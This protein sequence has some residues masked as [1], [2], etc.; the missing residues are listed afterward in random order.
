MARAKKPQLK[1]TKESMQA[2]LAANDKAVC[3]GLM[4]IYGNQTADEQAAAI[5]AEDNGIGFNGTDAEFMTEMAKFYTQHGRLTDGQMVWVRKKLM[6]YW[7][8]LCE[9]ANA[10]EA[11][12]ESNGQPDA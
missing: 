4:V 11:A 3:K 7:R 12:K 9:V 1:W 2:M 5:T 8:Q 10:N 6:K